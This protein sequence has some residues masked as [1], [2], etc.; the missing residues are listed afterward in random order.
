MAERYQFGRNLPDGQPDTKYNEREGVTTG[1]EDAALTLFYNHVLK[2]WT[3]NWMEEL[4]ADDIH[5]ELTE[6]LKINHERIVK[7]KVGDEV[8]F[9]I[10]DT[11]YWLRVV[12]VQ[13]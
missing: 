2:F 1:D 12:E 5:E 8:G 9:R 13:D 7:L 4:G 6:L 10:L 3:L 11:Y